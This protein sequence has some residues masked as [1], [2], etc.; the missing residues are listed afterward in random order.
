MHSAAI[1][2]MDG[3]LIASEPLWKIEERPV[4]ARVGIQISLE[5]SETMV[6]LRI[7]CSGVRISP[8]APPPQVL[9]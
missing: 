3:L 2:D 9:E 1:F 7:R 6:G 5:M 8:G 4:F